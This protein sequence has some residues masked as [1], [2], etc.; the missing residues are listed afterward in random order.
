MKLNFENIQWSLTVSIV[1]IG[2]Y[3]TPS[4]AEILCVKNVRAFVVCGFLMK[5]FFKKYA[6]NMK[7]ILGAIWELPAL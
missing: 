7:K 4:I 5:Y 3:Y 1:L 6:K 2:M